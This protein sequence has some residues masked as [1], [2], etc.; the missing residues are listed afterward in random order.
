MQ[1]AKKRVDGA[2]HHSCNVLQKNELGISFPFNMFVLTSP[3][4]GR[5]LFQ[6]HK[7]QLP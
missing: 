1:D 7:K 2:F 5:V 4:T 3:S 6:I